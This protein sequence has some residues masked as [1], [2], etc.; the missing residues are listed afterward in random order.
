MAR[1]RQTRRGDVIVAPFPFTDLTGSK[2]RPAVVL[3]VVG[4]SDY[5][6]C[7]VTSNAFAD[8]DAV[9]LARSDMAAGGLHR[10]SYAQLTKL[11]TGNESLIRKRVGRLTVRKSDELAQ[12]VIQFLTDSLNT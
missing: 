2:V 8:P 4:R 1:L 6:M 7:Q 11:F 12:R 10:R 5:L 3:A 9:E